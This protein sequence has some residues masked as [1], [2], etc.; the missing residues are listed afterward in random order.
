MRRKI[1]QHRLPEL[2]A[3]VVRTVRAVRIRR[4]NPSLT[5]V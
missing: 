1:R 3:Q 5:I 2:V 4:R